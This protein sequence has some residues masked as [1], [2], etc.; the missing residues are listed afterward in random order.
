M[1]R[2]VIAEIVGDRQ[3]EVEGALLKHRPHLRQ[4]LGGLLPHFMTI[5]A[6]RTAAIVVETG[7]QRE[8][9]RLAGA[10]RPQEHGEGAGVDGE[11]DIV[12]R[13]ALAEAMAQVL[14]GQRDTGVSMLL[15][16]TAYD[17]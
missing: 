2:R 17:L 14:H 5:N 3:I 4:G 7:D 6:D 16:I 9:R 11:G 12:E 1:Q 15:S 8:Q 10:V 13:F